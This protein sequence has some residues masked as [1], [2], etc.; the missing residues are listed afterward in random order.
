VNKVERGTDEKESLWKM[1]NSLKDRRFEWLT[2]WDEVWD[3]SFVKWWK[4]LMERSPDGHVF[5]EPCMVRAWYETYRNLRRIEPRFLIARLNSECAVFYPLVLDRGGWKDAWLRVIQPVGRN[6]F[7]YQ[8]PIVS[9]E[10]TKAIGSSFWQDIVDE[11][12]RMGGDFDILEIP[13]V[14]QGRTLGFEGFAE[15]GSAPYLELARFKSFE[16]LLMALSR[17]LRH[18]VRRQQR[19]LSALG[20]LTMDVLGKDGLKSAMEILPRFLSHYRARWEPTC[21]KLMPWPSRKDDFYK[22]LLANVLPSGFLHISVLKCGEK[23]ISWHVG[24]LYKRRFYADTATFDSA[25]SNYSPGKVHLAKLLEEAF[26]QQVE[27]FDFLAGAESY[28]LWWTQQAI[29][30]YRLSILRPGF[31]PWLRDNSRRLLRKAASLKLR[32]H[33]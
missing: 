31:L 12:S 21:S 24:F 4:E 2:R 11:L 7:D 33:N 5:F 13:R 29:G 19:H 17:N 32:R 27:V 3:P 18:D 22:N 14:R 30:L 6:E 16:Q 28:K 23:A 25:F 26:R 20:I 8:D 1:K 9:G 15:T 10:C